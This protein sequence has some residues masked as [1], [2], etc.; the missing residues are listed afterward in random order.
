MLKAADCKDPILL[1]NGGFYLQLESGLR[2]PLGLVISNGVVASPFRP[3]QNGGF[4]VSNGSDVKII[5]VNQPDAARRY[6]QAVQSTPIMVRSGRNDMRTDDGVLF[7]R[8]AVGRTKSGGLLVVGAFKEAGDAVSLF[9]MADF[10]V[11]MGKSGGPVAE[12]M[13]ALDGGPSASLIIPKLDLS[14]GYTSA[15]YLPNGIC[16]MGVND[17]SSSPR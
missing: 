11:S 8:I 13:L 6:K 3:R 1:T 17:G 4:L 14:F 2:K 12:D 15:N 10:M 9:Q 5:G 7:D 16:V